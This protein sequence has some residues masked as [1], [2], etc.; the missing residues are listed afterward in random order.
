[1]RILFALLLTLTFLEAASV[2]WQH[3]YQK[4]I[5]TAKTENKPLLIYLYLPG[6]KTCKY[7]NSHV[8]NDKDVAAFMAKNYIAVKLYPNDSDLPEKFRAEISPVFHVVNSQDSEMIESVLGGK[9]PEK[10]LELLEES[11]TAYRADTAE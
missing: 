6:C 5:N 3:N 1:M 11:Y 9:N 2:R 8:F 4:A 7:M 10:F